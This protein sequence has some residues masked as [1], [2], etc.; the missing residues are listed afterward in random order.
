L[1]KSELFEITVLTR[2]SST[3]TFPA[4]VKVAKVDYS[5]FDSLVA[6]LEGQDALVSTV[7]GQAIAGQRILIDAAVKAG[8]K[9]V[10]PSEFGCDLKNPKARALPVFKSKVEI[11]D[12]LDD[13]AVKGVLS[14]TLVFTGVFLD[15]G[16]RNGMFFN[17][18]DKTAKIYDGGDQLF[19]T[20]RLVRSFSSSILYMS[21]G[22]SITNSRRTG[23]RR[24]SRSSR[25]HPP[26]RNNRSRHLDQRHRH[27]S[28]RPSQT[29][30]SPHPWRKMDHHTRFH[31][32]ARKGIYKPNKEQGRRNSGDLWAHH[33]RDFWDGV[34]E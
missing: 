33:L 4:G 21:L 15:M 13:L 2:E 28:K 30:T 32:V 31:L 27:L 29:R 5:N 14:Y 34:W 12:Y 23:H 18:K 20:S 8:I 9:R 6:A 24:Q 17:F 10:I 1:L 3:A 25:P 7:G 16:L 26:S 11:E 19:S 22:L